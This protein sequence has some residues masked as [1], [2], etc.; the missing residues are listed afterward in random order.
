MKVDA[1]NNPVSIEEIKIWLKKK[2]K[3]SNP[4]SFTGNYIKHLKK[5]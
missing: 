5:R 4:D 3:P 1:Q 2:K